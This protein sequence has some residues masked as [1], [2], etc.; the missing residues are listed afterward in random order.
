MKFKIIDKIPQYKAFVYTFVTQLIVLIMG[1]ITIKLTTSLLETESFGVY[2][3]I[4]RSVS[5][6]SFPLLMG[7]G[8]SIPK[9]ISINH[10]NHEE[11]YKYI[12]AGGIILVSIILFF[13]F[14]LLLSGEILYNVLGVDN[15]YIN[16]KSILFLSIFSFN[17]YAFSY[18]ILKGIG[19]L[20][21]ANV[22]NIVCIGIAP[23]FSVIL[24]SD[25]INNIYYFN[26]LIVFLTCIVI[27]LGIKQKKQYYKYF[28]G[29]KKNY[30]ELMSFGVPR[31][32]GEF[33]LF[34]LFSIP[35]FIS[36]RM[37]SLEY[38]AYLSLAVS[39]FQLFAGMLEF[40][41]IV[42]FSKI[43]VWA[44]QSNWM[45]IREQ[46]SNLLILVSIYAVISIVLVWIFAEPIMLYVFGLNYIKSVPILRI[47]IFS[48]LPYMWYI[49]LR[50]IIDIISDFPYNTINLI[51][52][53]FV[54]VSFLYFKVLNIE[55][56]MLA[57]ISYIGIGNLVA[58]KIII[59]KTHTK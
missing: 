35:I 3:V 46:V 47:I 53:L 56:S 21:I 34:G 15:I 17:I 26:S 8:I 59:N 14:L 48:I 1:V 6:F 33:A 39:L 38:T 41:N 27:F 7:L 9:Y 20:R 54:I 11:V 40:I 57:G 44:S 4:R 52:G 31:V 5:L 49:S 30:K 25:N 32:L 13:L 19:E 24:F 28:C 36:A 45:K 12:L 2:N 51:T 43:G 58:Y 37:Y 50:N 10:N 22:I 55:K 42:V 18:S 16:L 23:M 29:L